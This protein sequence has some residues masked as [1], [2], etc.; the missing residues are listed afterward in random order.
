MKGEKTSA[1]VFFNKKRRYVRLGVYAVVL[2]SLGT[3][4]LI[5]KSYGAWF[6]LLMTAGIIAFEILHVKKSEKEFINYFTDAEFLVQ[7]NLH[8]PTTSNKYLIVKE[9]NKYSLIS[10]KLDTGRTHQI[11]VH[12]AYINHPLVGDVKYNSTVKASR[13][14]LHSHSVDFIH[15]ITK[16]KIYV[17]APFPEDMYRIIDEI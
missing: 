15:P 3:A 13:V 1:R 17:K 8:S 4:M 12:M 11:R 16:E 5:K 2:L 7:K 9:N 6:V 10:L 14:L